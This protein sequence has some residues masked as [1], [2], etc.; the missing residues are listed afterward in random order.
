MEPGII[1]YIAPTKRAFERMK[2][3]LF[4]PFDF[5]KWF[6][7]GFSAWLASLGESGGSSGGSGSDFESD[8]ESASDIIGETVNWIEENLILVMTIGIIIVLII[9]AISVI[10]LWVQSRGKFMFLDNVIHDRTR[11]SE[12]W[13]EFKD[14]ANS[15]FRWK[16]VYGLIVAFAIL[17]MAGWG[18]YL[19]W[20]MVKAEAFDMEVLPWLVTI[21]VIFTILITV[22]SYISTLLENFVIPLMH[23]DGLPTT[24]AWR[25][26]LPLH[27]EQA[28]AFVLFFLWMIVLGILTG[29]AVLALILATC[30]IAVIPL[31]IPYLGTVMMLPLYVFLRQV[32]PEFLK[33]FGE[34][35]DTLTIAAKTP[36]ALN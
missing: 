33:Q 26:L 20:P 32:G 21:G 16:L 25:K 13:K 28:G 9:V 2:D 11:I 10:V 34:E 23:R 30:C 1:E 12:P 17:S 7:L 22:L 6:I 14:I 18:F 29:L 24:V 5:Q 15:L 8:D 4:R 3:I 19:C 36:P 27:R 31:I 35:F